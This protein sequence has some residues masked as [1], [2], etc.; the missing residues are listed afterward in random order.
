M[1]IAPDVFDAMTPAEFVYA[2]TGWVEM[3]ENDMRRAW[4]RE[5]WAVWI[6]TSIQLD[7]KDRLPATQMFPLPWE[8]PETSP[9]AELT[10]E[11]RRERVKKL[12]T[13]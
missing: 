13:K 3:R 9:Q 7:R 11:E 12:L 1:G 6:L 4:E 8:A 2:W 10:M 5:R